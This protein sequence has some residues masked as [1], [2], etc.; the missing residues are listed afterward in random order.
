MEQFLKME[1][2]QN[3]PASFVNEIVEIEHNIG[4]KKTG[5]KEHH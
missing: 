4:S 3:I 2:V 5:Q 1:G